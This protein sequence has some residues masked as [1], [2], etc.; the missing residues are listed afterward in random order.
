VFAGYW[1]NPQATA[2]AI[3]ED[4]WLHTGDQGNLDDDGYLSITGRKK[5]LIVTAGG[6]NVAP[7]VLEDRIRAHP[8][9]S[10]VMVVGDQQPF[11]AA[12]ITLDEEAL[13]AWKE[14]HHKPAEATVP[15][16]KEDPDLLAEIQAA[17]DDANRVVSK[18]ESI[19]AFR[20]LNEDFTE[21]NGMLTPSL[22][23]KRAVV[24]KEY[25]DEITAIYS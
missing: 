17:V 25:A 1:N 21:S 23:V 22:K 2:E 14:Q 4:G 20:I 9:V 11:I 24:A 3:D 16:L 5:E 15:E 19:R 13:P 6:K 7:A 8:L 10:Q 18:A 12:L